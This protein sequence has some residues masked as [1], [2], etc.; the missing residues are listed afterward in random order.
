VTAK[1]KYNEI[2]NRQRDARSP[3]Y[4]QGVMAWL[5]YKL[6]KKEIQVPYKKG[7]C[8]FDAFFSGLDEGKTY[9]IN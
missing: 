2:F 9:P 1:E 8:Q 5:Q 3:E 7:T 6:E 4:K